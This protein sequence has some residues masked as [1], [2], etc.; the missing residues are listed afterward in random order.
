MSKA[1]DGDER[2]ELNFTIYVQIFVFTFFREVCMLTKRSKLFRNLQFLLVCY[3]E[4]AL[5]DWKCKNFFCQYTLPFSFNEYSKHK[6]SNWV[7]REHIKKYDVIHP[8][9]DYQSQPSRGLKWFKISIEETDPLSFLI[10]LKPEF[11]VFFI[12]W[13]DTLI[14]LPIILKWWQ[15]W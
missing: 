4:M 11:S 5:S 9:L 12:C 13:L 1:N 6:C 8:T 2:V 15:H 7:Y 14:V 10:I 3:P